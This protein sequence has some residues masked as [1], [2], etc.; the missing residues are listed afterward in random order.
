ML[1]TQEMAAPPAGKAYEL[2]LRDD[3]GTMNPAGLMTTAGDHKLLLEGDAAEA[4]GVGITVEPEQGSEQPDQRADR[5][6]RARQGRL[7]DPRRTR[8]VAVIGSGVA[9]LTAAHVL[10]RQARVTLYEADS[11]LGGHA[12]THVVDGAGSWPSTPASSCTT[13]APTRTCC[14][15]STSSACETQESDMS[16]SVRSDDPPDLGVGRRARAGRPVPDR[17]ATRCVRRTCGC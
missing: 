6:V 7:H 14:G 4:T 9:G 15:S 5:H 17:G 11:R 10:G 2:W 1:L 12:D 8:H 3:A 16:M 13:S